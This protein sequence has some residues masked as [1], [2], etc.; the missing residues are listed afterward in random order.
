MLMGICL[1]THAV[2]ECAVCMCFWC[3]VLVNVFDVVHVCEGLFLCM[4]A[5]RVCLM[6]VRAFLSDKFSRAYSQQYVIVLCVWSVV[7]L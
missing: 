4:F 2:R 5:V 6:P 7:L 3:V 1:D